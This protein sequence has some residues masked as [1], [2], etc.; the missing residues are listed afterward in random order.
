MAKKIQGG[1]LVFTVGDDGTLK[2]LEKK[3]KSAKKAMNDLGGASQSTDRRIKGV[4]QQSSNATK[5]FSKQAQT[6]QGGIVAVYATIAAQVF[7]VSA[8]FQFLKDSMET[9]NLIQGQLAFGAVTGVAY[10]TMTAD[11]QAA[12]SG[13]IQFK[14]AAQAAAI[15]TAAGLTSGQMEAIGRAAKNTSLALGR[16]LTDSFN[17]LTRGITKAEPELLD[18]LGIVLRLEPAMKAYA[19]TIGK[20]AKDLTQFEKS[21]AVANEVLSQAETKFGAITKVLDPSAFALAQFG[22]AFD[23]M[24]KGVKETVGDIAAAVLP[25]FSKNIYALVGALTLFLTP[26]L[27]SILPDF[28]A[29]G[30]AAD[31]NYGKAAA[32]ADEAAAAAQRAKAALSGAQGKGSADALRD[33]DYMKKHGIKSGKGMPEGQLS[34]RQLEIRKKHLREGVGFSKNMNKQQ[35]AAYKRF[36]VDQEIALKVSDSK[37][38]NIITRGQFR[39]RALYAQTAAFYKKTQMMM[40]AATAKASKLMNGAMRLMGWVGIALM[41]F[42]AVRALYQWIKGVDEAAEAEK[43]LA[44]DITDRY[45]SLTVEISKMNEIAG[46]GLLGF[47]GTIEQ[48][49]SAFQSVDLTKTMQEYT[50]AL[51]IKDSDLQAEALEKIT[52]SLTELSTLTQNPKA[53]TDL[54]ELM[55][56]K[57]AIDDETIKNVTALTTEFGNAAMSSKTFAE[58][59]KAVVNS[60]RQMA[61]TGAKV[62]GSSVLEN[63][64]KNVEGRKQQLLLQPEVTAQKDQNVKDKQ[65]ALDAL[66][67]ASKFKAMR[68]SIKDMGGFRS[69]QEQAAFHTEYGMSLRKAEALLR[70]EKTIL[71]QRKEAVQA[72]KNAKD[73]QEATKEEVLAIEKA[74]EREELIVANIEKLQGRQLDLQKEFVQ[75]K[76]D[77]V[78]VGTGTTVADKAAKLELKNAAALTDE[79]DKQLKLDMATEALRV[80]EEQDTATEEEIKGLKQ[81]LALAGLNL[82]LSTKQKEQTAE[83]VE[84]KKLLNKQ[85]QAT[86]E[87]SEKHKANAL[88][89]KLDEMENAAAIRQAGTHSEVR[90]LQEEKL[91]RMREKAN[92]D[93]AKRELM[94]TQLA[95]LVKQKGHD[96]EDARKRQIAIN[97]LKAEELIT[98]QMITD[99]MNKQA[100]VD[101]SAERDRGIDSSRMKVQNM[102]RGAGLPGFGMSNIT[103]QA[104]ELNKILVQENTTLAELQADQTQKGKEHLATILKQ[105]D[106]QAKMGIELE[107]ANKTSDIMKQGFDSLFQSLLDGTQSFGD[108]MKGVMKQVL[109]DLAAAYMSAAA[110]TALRAIGLPGLPARYGGVMSSSGKSFAVGGV[111]SG[112]ESGYMATLHG[113]EAVVPLGNDR[114]IPVEM[115]GG[116]GGNTVNVTVNMSGGQADTSTTGD[117]AMQ[118][119]GRSIGGLVQQHLQQEM[120]PGGLLNQQGTKGRT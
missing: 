118:G 116:G 60:L 14:E 47:K 90:V 34:K 110:M 114:S 103:P 100:G 46:M 91:T 78:G 80:A 86:L 45:G 112:P 93:V 82:E 25:F 68:Q 9:R 40:V 83:E 29:M 53:L 97:N 49:G 84:L 66:P 106:A 8:A 43:K 120:R 39:A 6:M 16:D 99:E 119:L 21:Q 54:I 115:R 81:T 85:S 15:G 13:M 56:K 35:L 23:D 98:E 101:R 55:G 104:R 38:A 108:A 33:T 70:K 12:T 32:A 1:Q 95:N 109:A 89:R 62:F 24:M 117:G 107:L 77:A 61:G 30:A 111:A 5:N 74:L 87:L 4:T 72:L 63:M 48:M 22:K 44:G 113:T 19:N 2:L 20:N 7:A 69:Q 75:N 65:A 57:G 64:K 96:E 26:I 52:T 36:L 59:N 31:E 94:E 27:K 3:T 88:A 73:N 11:I 28:A 10:K 71:E 105:A 92:D 41:I 102:T 18:E 50:K 17:R 76:I 51:A 67:D 79:K 42:E 37:R 58:N